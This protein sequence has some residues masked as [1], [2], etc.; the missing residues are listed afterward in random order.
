MDALEVAQRQGYNMQRDSKGMWVM[1]L[2][3]LKATQ[4]WAEVLS[5]NL[6][7]QANK[8]TATNKQ[9]NK[10]TSKQASKQTNK[11]TNKQTK[12]KQ[13][14]KRLELGDCKGGQKSNVT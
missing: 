3:L 13:Q 14:T 11:Q 5:I 2:V 10:Q 7:K 9:T 6:D 12:S 1:W 8:N 4:R